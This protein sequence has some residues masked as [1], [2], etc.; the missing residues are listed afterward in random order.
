MKGRGP[1]GQMPQRDEEFQDVVTVLEHIFDVIGITKVIMLAFCCQSCLVFFSPVPQRCFE[2][3]MVTWL[4]KIS[5]G[6]VEL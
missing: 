4:N 2:S 6:D 5:F 3:S 1:L